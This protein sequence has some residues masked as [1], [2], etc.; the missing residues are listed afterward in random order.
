MRDFISVNGYAPTIR[1][2]AA[3]VGL[4]S[5][6]TVEEHLQ[7]LE[8]K[9]VIKRIRGRK[10]AIEIRAEFNRASGN[11][12]PILGQIAA[13]EPIEAIEDPNSHVDFPTSESPEACFALRVKGQSMVEDGIFNGDIVIIRRQETCQNGDMVVALLEDS[14]A[15]LKRLYRENKRIRLQPAN[16]EFEPL[17]VKRVRIQGRVVGLVRKF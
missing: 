9:G 15:T 2:I 3:G 1:E 8:H 4:G 6:A 16:S 10:R 7:T 13:G 5:P 17:Y 14:S 11:R 12:I